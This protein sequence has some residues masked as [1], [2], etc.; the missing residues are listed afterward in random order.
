MEIEDEVTASAE[1]VK[2]IRELPVV[3]E[4]PV[5]AKEEGAVLPPTPPKSD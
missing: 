3:E 2:P 5:K 4:T 1:E